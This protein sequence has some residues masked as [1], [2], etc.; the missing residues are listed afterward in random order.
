MFSQH[1]EEPQ[2]HSETRFPFYAMTPNHNVLTVVFILRSVK[3]FKSVMLGKNLSLTVIGLDPV[4]GEIRL[5]EKWQ[6]TGSAGQI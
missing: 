1:V 3:W 5:R 2:L 6:P 4:H